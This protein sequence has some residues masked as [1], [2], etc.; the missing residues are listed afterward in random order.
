[1]EFMTYFRAGE[2]V[3]FASKETLKKLALSWLETMT[4][5]AAKVAEKAKNLNKRWHILLVLAIDFT[6]K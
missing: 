5:T 1:M 3:Y 2:L 4:I 6:K